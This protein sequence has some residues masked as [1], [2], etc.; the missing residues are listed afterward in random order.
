MNIFVKYYIRITL[1]R[2]AST[3]LRVLV[4]AEDGVSVPPHDHL[5]CS[6]DAGADGH[7]LGQLEERTVEVRP[8][9]IFLNV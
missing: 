1:T 7:E 2:T 8:D 3:Y 4:L 9:V 6:L 5:V